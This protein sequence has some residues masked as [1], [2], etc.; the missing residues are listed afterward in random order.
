LGGYSEHY[1]FSTEEILLALLVVETAM[2]LVES[3][4]SDESS[5]K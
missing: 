2:S 4:P 5:R 3:L 1:N